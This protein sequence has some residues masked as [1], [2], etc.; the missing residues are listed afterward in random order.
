MKIQE[1]NQY[2]SAK[3]GV[4]VVLK[5]REGIFSVMTNHVHLI[6]KPSQQSILS[7]AI[8]ET[9]RRYI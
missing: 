3:E 7:K 1:I 5:S 6:F 8:A 4:D 2:D 9:H